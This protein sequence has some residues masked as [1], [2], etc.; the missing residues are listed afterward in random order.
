MARSAPEDKFLLV[1]RLNGKQMPKDQAGWEELHP[2][3]DW[4]TERDL[5]LPG[6]KE[7]WDRSHPVMIIDSSHS[8]YTKTRETFTL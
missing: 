7:E 4:A 6:Y 3:R 8:E 5:L 1:T 2:G